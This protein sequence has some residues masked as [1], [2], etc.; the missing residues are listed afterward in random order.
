MFGDKKHPD[1]GGWSTSLHSHLSN[2]IHARGNLSNGR[3]WRSNG[4]VYSAQ[5]MRI[6][7]H[8]FLETYVLL[9]LLAKIAQ[10][11]PALPRQANIL[12]TYNSRRRYLRELDWK[13]CGFVNVRSSCDR[14]RLD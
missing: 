12:F 5:G 6:G 9:L 2:F 13:L 11:S 14:S 8:S 7:Y 3:I 1:P 4:P 10:P